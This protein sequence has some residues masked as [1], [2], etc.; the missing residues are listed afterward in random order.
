MEKLEIQNKKEKL[1]DSLGAKYD[2]YK[3]LVSE[4]WDFDKH[5]ENIIEEEL[6]YNKKKDGYNKGND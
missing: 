6:L 2:L 5:I 4:K 1:K 3:R